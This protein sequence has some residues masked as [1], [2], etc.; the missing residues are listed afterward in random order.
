[1]GTTDEKSAGDDFMAGFGGGDD[2]VGT[3]TQTAADAAGGEA[4][5]AGDAGADTGA[6]GAHAGAGDADDQG[7]AAGV[8][9]AGSGEQGQVQAEELNLEELPDNVRQLVTS[10]R[11]N[12]QQLDTS[13]AATRRERDAAVGRVAPLQQQLTAYQRAQQQA[14]VT[15]EPRTDAAKAAVNAAQQEI[16]TAIARFDSDEFKKYAEAWPEEAKMLRDTQLSTLNLIK[17][18]RIEF[19]EQ[20]G[21]VG[22]MVQT[23][24][25]P[26]LESLRTDREEAQRAR[27]VESLAAEHPDWQDLNKSDEFWG[28]FEG[29]R[30]HLNYS[31][32]EHMRARLRDQTHVS[33][34]LTRFKRETGYGGQAGQQGTAAP[35]KAPANARMALAGGRPERS[36]SAPVRRGVGGVTSGDD[37]MAGFNS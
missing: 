28:W 30:E 22:R 24:I 19:A 29:E 21:S 33:H 3:T 11:E 4:D 32:D 31:D 20:I 2:E 26:Q 5:G 36:Q 34:L 25:A 10:L 14:A 16:D 9:T 6:G 13:L 27:A 35:S 15:G 7:A 1:M 17:Q 37:F 8:D 18:Q 23:Q 12:N